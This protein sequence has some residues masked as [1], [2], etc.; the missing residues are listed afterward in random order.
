MPGAARARYGE[1]IPEVLGVPARILE[2]DSSPLPH[3][4]GANMRDRFIAGLD[5]AGRLEQTS[6]AA[7]PQPSTLLRAAPAEP[8]EVHGNND[9][10]GPCPGA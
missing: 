5:W 1:I 9:P 8:E 6:L 7:P 3:S 10:S 4:L 2:V